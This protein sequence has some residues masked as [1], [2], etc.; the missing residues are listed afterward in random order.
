VKTEQLTITD[1]DIPQKRTVVPAKIGLFGSSGSGK[2][3]TAALLAVATSV[4]LHG[5][6][7]VYVYDTE[8]GWQFMKRIFD[9]E[10]VQLTQ[11]V[12]RSFEGMCDHIEKAEKSG[13]CVFIVDSMTHTWTELMDTFAG[14]NGR[15]EFQQFNLI[16]RNWNRWATSFLNSKMHCYALGRLGWEYE[17][18][19]NEKN[20]RKEIIKGDSKFKA[21]GGESF[22]YEPHL[23]VE[24][25]LGR[26]DDHNGRGGKLVHYATVLKD[27][28]RMLDGAEFEFRGFPGYKKGDYKAVWDAFFPHINELQ[29]LSGHPAIGSETSANL[30]PD[31]DGEWQRSQQA[32]KIAIEDLD[33]TIDKLWPGMTADAKLTRKAVFEFCFDGI[34]SRTEME[35]QPLDRLQFAAALMRGFEKEAKNSM[36]TSVEGILNV[37]HN[38]KQSLMEQPF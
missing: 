18:Q 19:V 37:L 4:E 25:E 11:V 28:A 20:G 24:M 5:K 10:G 17:T 36:P 3:T 30:V 9:T 12:S 33:E 23:L 29:L 13:A 2:T 7:P 14:K 35:N 1:K 8:P 32:R 26:A 6:A 34:R 15:V 21:G 31:G 27:R 38:L 16:K 22:G